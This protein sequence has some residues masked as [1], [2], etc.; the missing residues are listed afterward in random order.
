[1]IAGLILICEE[2]VTLRHRLLAL[3]P[4]LSPRRGRG[5]RTAVCRRERVRPV[6]R[7][8]RAL[9]NIRSEKAEM[10]QGSLDQNRD[11]CGNESANQDDR[12]NYPKMRVGHSIY[13]VD[14]QC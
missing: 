6:P 9:L 7:S 14:D 10:N 1:M 2:K 11:D 8:Y 4:A 3:T 5:C 12:N 13:Q